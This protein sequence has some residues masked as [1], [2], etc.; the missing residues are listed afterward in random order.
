MTRIAVFV[1]GGGTNLQALIDAE[2][3]GELHDGKIVLVICNNPNAY[4]LKRA[5]AAGIRHLFSKDNEE[6]AALL[7]E[8]AIDLIVLAGY[9]AIVPASLI[10]AYPNRIMNIHPSLIPSFCGKGY[11]GL[12]VHE[13]AFARGVKVSGATVHFVSEEVD[14]GPIIIQRAVDVSADESP[15]AMQQT[16]LKIEHQILKEAIKLFCQ[17]RLTV[18]KERV[19]IKCQEH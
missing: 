2:I 12:H 17:K 19:S 16:V 9:L 6:I 3:N 7:K 14:G 4:A 5:E 18:E 13:K 10:K 11:Y 15:E 1:S 8:E